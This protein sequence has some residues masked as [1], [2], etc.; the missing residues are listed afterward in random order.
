LAPAP[1]QHVI[2]EFTGGRLCPLDRSLRDGRPLFFVP[3][4]VVVAQESCGATVSQS[5]HRVLRLGST[6]PQSTNLLPDNDRSHHRL[7]SIAVP[8]SLPIIFKRSR[9]LCA[10]VDSLALSYFGAVSLFTCP[11]GAEVA[12]SPSTP[13]DMTRLFISDFEY[14]AVGGAG[15]PGSIRPGLV[16]RPSRARPAAGVQSV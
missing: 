14:G 12:A 11:A 4:S 5:V 3:R 8:S 6:C 9:H 7:L 15:S 2:G 1:N 16:E 10:C 13:R